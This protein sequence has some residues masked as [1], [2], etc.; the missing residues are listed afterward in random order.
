MKTSVRGFGDDLVRRVLFGFLLFPALAGTASA[1]EKEYW[2]GFPAI[3][4]TQGERIEKV[5]IE[6]DC[7]Q[8]SD[9]SIVPDWYVST[10][11]RD[12][13][14]SQDLVLEGGNGATW[15]MSLGPLGQ[16]VRIRTE[17]PLP[18]CFNMTAEV[19]VV[20]ANY[21]TIKL[22]MDRLRLVP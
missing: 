14:I 8:F 15:L 3:S 6:L 7:G 18:K 20:G 2:L 11:R 9:V 5:A 4:L 1:S 19:F 16:K 17:D 22:G 13:S 12:S 10:S 21:R